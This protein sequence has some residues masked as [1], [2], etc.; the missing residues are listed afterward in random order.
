MTMKQNKVKLENITG[1][2]ARRRTKLVI[3][4]H[5]DSI[6]NIFEVWMHGVAGSTGGGYNCAVSSD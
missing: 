5:G 6:A 3:L 4:N 2:A 1:E